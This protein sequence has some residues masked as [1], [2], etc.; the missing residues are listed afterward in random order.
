MIDKMVN[1]FG[2]IHLLKMWVLTEERVTNLILFE[3]DIRR[4]IYLINK[5]PR[6]YF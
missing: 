5:S 1:D 3:Y 6:Q 2:K 4:N